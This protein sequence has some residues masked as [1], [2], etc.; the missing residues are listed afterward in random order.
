M[1]DLPAHWDSLAPWPIPGLRYSVLAPG[2]DPSS[3]RKKRPKFSMLNASLGVR[4]RSATLLSRSCER[5]SPLIEPKPVV[6]PLAV[7][8]VKKAAQGTN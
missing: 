7:K 2:R 1:S 3:M 6:V 8:P 4:R 5:F